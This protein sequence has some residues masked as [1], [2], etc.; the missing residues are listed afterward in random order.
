MILLKQ[1]NAWSCGPTAL[2]MLLGRSVDEI[3]SKIGHDGSE[4]VFPNEPEPVCRRAF[5]V[6]ELID[7][8]FFEYGMILLE[9]N[10]CPA[11]STNRNPEGFVIYEFNWERRLNQYMSGSSGL[12]MGQS[13][14]A[15]SHMMAWDGLKI[16]DP[17][18]PKKLSLSE[19]NDFQIESFFLGIKS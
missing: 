2:A 18:E 12:V 3:I 17:R 11:T 4:I 6:Q 10:A 15:E 8:A 16:Y 13:N 19:L 14:A 7:C 9:I 5:H 1:P